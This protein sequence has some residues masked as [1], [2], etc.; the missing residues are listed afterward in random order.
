MTTA[1]TAAGVIAA[2]VIVAS[3]IDGWCGLLAK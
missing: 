3:F 1:L 2:V